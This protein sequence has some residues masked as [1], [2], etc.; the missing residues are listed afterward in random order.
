MERM[1]IENSRKLAEVG[2]QLKDHIQHDALRAVQQE[3]HRRFE[4]RRLNELYSAVQRIENRLQ[5]WIWFKN[6]VAWAFG[7]LGMAV[8]VGWHYGSQLMHWIKH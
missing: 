3:E 2:Q 5:S 8:W 6:G 4:E 7:L 1:T